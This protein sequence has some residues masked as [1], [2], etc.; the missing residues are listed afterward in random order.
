MSIAAA[1][2]PAPMQTLPGQH[3][4]D[5]Q[6]PAPWTPP[7]FAP[8]QSPSPISPNPDDD[9]EMVTPASDLQAAQCSPQGAALQPQPVSQ[10]AS[11]ATASPQPLGAES[12]PCL[13]VGPPP[14]N[15]AAS[16]H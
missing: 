4:A 5:A 10:P 1:T 12:A 8:G 2:Q 3:I 15:M 13:C 14:P 9:V 11:S 7:C 16:E 6:P